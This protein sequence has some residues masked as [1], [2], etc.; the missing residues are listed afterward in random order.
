MLQLLMPILTPILKGLLGEA[1]SAVKE[2]LN[3]ILPP[4]KMSERERAEL[5]QEL[6]KVKLLLENRAEERITESEKLFEQ[7]VMT[8][9]NKPRWYRDIVRP[10]IT[11]GWFGF[12]GWMKFMVVT[13][14]LEDG[15]SYPGDLEAIFNGYDAMIGMSIIAFWFGPKMVE[16][17]LGKSEWLKSLFNIAIK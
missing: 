5:N 3:R 4:E 7:R 6:E 1:F 9:Y 17:L 12:Y 8:E 2:I 16:R 10:G 11:M 14:V 13:A 15:F